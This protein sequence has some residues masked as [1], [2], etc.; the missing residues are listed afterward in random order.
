MLHFFP[1][2]H[3]NID[4]CFALRH[5]LLERRFDAILL[6]QPADFQ[7]ELSGAIEQLPA[8]SVCLFSSVDQ[9]KHFYCSTDPSEIVIEALRSGEAHRIPVQFCLPNITSKTAPI[10]NPLDSSLISTLGYHSYISLLLR[11][12]GAVELSS[13][14]QEAI[15]D[16]ARIASANNRADK[17]ILVC[18]HVS[19]F[20]A[21][22]NQLHQLDNSPPVLHQKAKSIYTA[23][24]AALAID[25]MYFACS[26]LPFILAQI[27]QNR[28]DVLQN[29]INRIDALSRLFSNTRDQWLK[30][31]AQKRQF[32][33]T[34]IQA[35]LQF[36]R[37]LSQQQGRIFPSLF[38][39]ITAARGVGGNGFALRVLQ[40]AKY[41]PF[42]DPTQAVAKVGIDAVKMPGASEPQQAQNWFLDQEFVWQKISLKKEPDE[43]HSQQYRFAWDPQQMCSHLPE[44]RRIEQFNTTVRK[45]AEQ[46]MKAQLSSSEKF[47]TSLFD[48]IDIR[49][50]IR[51]RHTGG[52]YVR[53][54][55]HRKDPI[56]SVVILFDTNNDTRYPQ[57]ATW[58]A[59]HTE[60][61]TLS[62]YATDPFSDMIGPGIARCHYGGLHLLFPPRPIIPIHERFGH[63]RFP[64]LAHQLV[65]GALYYSQQRKIALCSF[66]P[67]DVQ[68]KRYARQLHKQI[69]WVSLARFSE[70]TRAKL[71]IFHVLNGKGVRS[72]ATRFIA[73]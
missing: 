9:K 67:P 28:M 70:E 5:T 72:W 1:Y 38:D 71:R 47:S 41:Y 32:S 43:K 6:D 10:E 27:E 66:S 56:E 44:D 46:H 3:G 53:K 51:N 22:I 50:T 7:S 52:I 64:S 31:Q 25:S 12:L 23:R 35:A 14:W 30:S 39:I 20:A 40:N 34:R 63:R 55:P 24:R 54:F 60:E 45:R 16:Y 33:Y 15:A 4:V 37:S 69:I 68:M 11:H 17:H 65:Y 59:E 21:F 58:Y 49:E 61:S 62:F 19:R 29:P 26:E 36:L 42:F 48:G 13:Q 2:I 8:V 18:C 57:Q 73:E